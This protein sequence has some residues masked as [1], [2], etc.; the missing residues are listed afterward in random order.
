MIHLGSASKDPSVMVVY[1]VNQHK[2]L[3]LSF[4]DP[5]D[6]YVNEIIGKPVHVVFHAY[7]IQKTNVEDSIF[8]K[9]APHFSKALL[10]KIEYERLSPYFAYRPHYVIQHT[11][12]QTTQ[13]DKSTIHYPMQGHL[14]S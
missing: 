11:L 5:A 7:C 4:Y 13:L 12:K 3:K 8:V 2:H 9:T 14:K 10:S 6:M 1:K